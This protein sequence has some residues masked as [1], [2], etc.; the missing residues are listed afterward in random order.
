MDDFQCPADGHLQHYD[1]LKRSLDSIQVDKKITF[2]RDRTGVKREDQR[3]YNIIGKCA[4]FAETITKIVQNTDPEQI[5]EH[6]QN[7]IFLCGAA[8]LGY[9]G[10]EAANLFVKGE[11]GPEAAR[12]Y[13]GVQN[14]CPLTANRVELLSNVIQLANVREQQQQQQKSARGIYLGGKTWNRNK[15]WNQGYSDQYYQFTGRKIPIG[16]PQSGWQSQGW[17]SDYGEQEEY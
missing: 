3:T 7:H 6:T 11:Y 10:E 14:L 9:L 4:N 13:R 1:Q 16:R 2:T 8:Q 12:L 5:T 15:P 17:Y